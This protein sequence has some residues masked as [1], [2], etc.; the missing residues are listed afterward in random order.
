MFAVLLAEFPLLAEEDYRAH[1]EECLQVMC[2]QT[3]GYLKIGGM[4]TKSGKFSSHTRIIQERQKDGTVRRREEHLLGE[5]KPYPPQERLPPGFLSRMDYF[6]DQGWTS[7]WTSQFT[8]WGIR[9]PMRYY[10]MPKGSISGREEEFRGKPCWVILVEGKAG[11]KKRFWEYVVEKER[12][13]LHERRVI[14]EDGRLLMTTAYQDFT[15][16][17]TIPPDAFQVPKLDRIIFISS[18]EEW[19]DAHMRVIRE[20]WEEAEAVLQGK[21]PPKK[22]EPALSRAWR[23]LRRSPVRVAACGILLLAVLSLGTALALKHRKT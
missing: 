10:E 3:I 22:Q 20:S 18:P 4:G 17:P 6:T 15:F 21:A 2:N 8:R 19:W 7:V 14:N 23:R 11:G 1:L 5:E 9:D 13:V 16:S 12:H